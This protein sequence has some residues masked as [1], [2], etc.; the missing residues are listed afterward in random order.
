MVEDLKSPTQEVAIALVGKYTQL[1]DA[2][3]SVVEALKHGG[4]PQ[5]AT[6]N[7]KWVDSEQ[8][9]KENVAEILKDVDGI[10]VP[11]GFGG[12]GIE[13]MIDAICYARENSIPFLGLCLGMQLAIV[14]FVRDVVGYNDAHSIELNPI[15]S[16]WEPISAIRPLS[17]TRIHSACISVV[18]RWEIRIT[19]DPRKFFFSA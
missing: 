11:G 6:V 1:H 19:V 10:L 7:I 17:S 13:G 15:N 5:H 4:I 2:Y 12:R 16:S 3:I 9:N 8:V 14:E 18:T